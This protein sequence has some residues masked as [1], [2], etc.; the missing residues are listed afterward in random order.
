MDLYNIPGD[1]GTPYRRKVV[2][3]LLKPDY[4]DGATDFCMLIPYADKNELN[5]NERVW[6]AYLY[7]LSYSCTTAIRLF[8]VVPDEKQLDLHSLKRFWKSEKSTL[9]FNPDRKYLK[10]NDQVI[11][12]IKGLVDSL[13]W[14]TLFDS[15]YEAS[16]HKKDFDSLYK[17]I[18]KD[19]KFFGPM[20]AY[21]FF[22]AL[23][24]LCPKS[25]YVD[26]DKLDWKH[27]GKTVVEGMAHMLYQDELIETRQF[28]LA[29]FDHIVDKLQK[30]TGKP[31]V[32]IESTL[33]AFRKYFK[34]S[35]YLGYY[36]DRM[37]EECHFVDDNA[38]IDF[39]VWELRKTVP[40]DLRGEVQGWKGI[41]KECM[42]NWLERGE[43]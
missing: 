36:A 33:C 12:A 11:P 38:S 2:Q 43:L 42:H 16:N 23:Y 30:S 6:L 9:W 26:P 27:S 39:D 21:L 20:G 32:M 5:L 37:L 14:R 25:V 34:G 17:Y 18:L 31:K 22:D 8:E 35:R 40:D 10:N 29:R 13:D 1:T 15:V 19:W 4:V 41:R 3:K 28:P 24:G 7:G